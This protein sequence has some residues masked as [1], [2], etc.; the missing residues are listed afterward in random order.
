MNI[1][2][3]IGAGFV[4]IVIGVVLAYATDYVCVAAGLFPADNLRVAWWIILFVVL[5]RS[6]YTTLGCYVAA[7]LAPRNA[8]ALVLTLGIVGFVVTLLGGIVT[9]NQ[10]LAP[11]WY[12]I[13]LAILA[14]P[15]S[16]FG[17]VLAMKKRT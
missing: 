11:H 10:N 9:W 17:G 12:C 14:I 2:R 3:N 4:A 5:Y 7:K 15:S 6:I 13:M 1:L 8:M 16:W